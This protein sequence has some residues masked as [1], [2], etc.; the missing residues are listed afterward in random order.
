MVKV[1]DKY[2]KTK[3]AIERTMKIVQRELEDG[4]LKVEMLSS[5]VDLRDK[6]SINGTKPNKE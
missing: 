5:L 4:K 6:I 2:P 3:E 1:K